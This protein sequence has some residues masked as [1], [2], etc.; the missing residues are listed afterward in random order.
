M[1]VIEVFGGL[2]RYLKKLREE[3]FHL[4]SCLERTP[5]IFPRV[6]ERED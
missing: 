2:M 5:E 3:K 4:T 1:K 6:W